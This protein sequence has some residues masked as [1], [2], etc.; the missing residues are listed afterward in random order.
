[1]LVVAKSRS[2]NC[3]ATPSIEGLP[4]YFYLDIKVP[5]DQ[6]CISQ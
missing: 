2:L 1:M 4:S 6:G 3:T 5:K